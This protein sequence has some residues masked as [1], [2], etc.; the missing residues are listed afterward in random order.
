[1]LG[2]RACC[3]AVPR[4]A[5]APPTLEVLCAYLLERG[6][7]RNKLPERLEIVAEMPLTPTRK[8]IKGK[9]RERLARS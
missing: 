1:V 9:L 2:E 5:S 6:V 8:I 7:A 3:V 4:D